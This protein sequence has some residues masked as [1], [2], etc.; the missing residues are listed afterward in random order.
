MKSPQIAIVDYGMGNL[1]S[2]YQ[3]LLRVGANPVIATSSHDI[4][5]ADKVILPGVGAFGHCMEHLESSGLMPVIHEVIAQEKPFL[6]IC[7]GMQVL[8]QRSDE[9]SDTSG[10]GV[11]PG[12]VKHFDFS[13]KQTDLKVPHM[14]WNSIHIKQPNHA[15]FETISEGSDFYFVHSFYVKP[16]SPDIVATTTEY[17]HEFCSMIIKDNVAACQ[18]HPEKSQAAGLQLLTNFMNWKP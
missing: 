17:G 7:L 9:S 1:K 2:V 12:E 3:A 18:F 4:A 13:G 15:L 16:Q 6:G 5:E 10:L 11:F 8:F 14:G